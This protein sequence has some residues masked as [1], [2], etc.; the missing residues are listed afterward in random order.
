MEP[1]LIFYFFFS[2]F[3]QNHQTKAPN[4]QPN[5]ASGGL[6][7]GEEIVAE[8]LRREARSRSRTIALL[9]RLLCRAETRME[10]ETQTQTKVKRELHKHGRQKKIVAEIL[11]LYY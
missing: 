9:A 2:S 10:T 5:P 11:P 1:F 6:I 4:I 3:P 8:I 7:G